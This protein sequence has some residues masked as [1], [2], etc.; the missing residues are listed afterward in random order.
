ML[1]GFKEEMDKKNLKS[2]KA[3]NVGAE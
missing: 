3:E 1:F 2:K